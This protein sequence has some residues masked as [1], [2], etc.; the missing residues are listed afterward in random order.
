MRLEN[1]ESLLAHHAEYAAIH[2]AAYGLTPERQLDQTTFLDY[3][4]H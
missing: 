1:D 4:K 2:E 3:A